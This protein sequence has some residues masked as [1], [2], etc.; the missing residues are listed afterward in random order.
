VLPIQVGSATLAICTTISMT[1]IPEMI[2]RR[3]CRANMPA[4]LRPRIGTV[5][6]HQIS[7]AAKNDP[8]AVP[9][10]PDCK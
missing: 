6:T 2:G 7:D 5:S 4:T 3:K 9:R 8:N 1:I 10:P